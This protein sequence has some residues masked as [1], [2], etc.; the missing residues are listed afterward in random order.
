MVGYKQNHDLFVFGT[1][2]VHL[3]AEKAITQIIEIPERALNMKDLPEII[4][5]Y[6]GNSITT[7]RE[8]EIRCQ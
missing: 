7:E 4:W 2:N 8:I 5:D 6:Q 3:F 1:L